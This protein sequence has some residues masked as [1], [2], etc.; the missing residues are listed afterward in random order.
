VIEITTAFSETGFSR[1][2]ATIR[3]QDFTGPIPENYLVM[4][5]GSTDDLALVCNEM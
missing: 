3:E 4:L 2:Q 5:V 1:S